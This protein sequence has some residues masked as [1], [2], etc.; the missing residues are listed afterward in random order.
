MHIPR[1][2]KKNF[3]RLSDTASVANRAVLFVFEPVSALS[4]DRRSI[5]CLLIE[6][7]HEE[8]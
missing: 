2:R 7:E 4:K 3:I 1:R 5:V 8:G 6:L